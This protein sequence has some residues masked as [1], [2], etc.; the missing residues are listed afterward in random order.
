MKSNLFKYSVLSVGIV[1]AMGITGI[2]IAAETS[3]GST[4]TITNVATATY[5]VGNVLQTEVASNPVKVNITQSAAFNLTADNADGDKTDDYNKSIVVTP[6]GRVSF[7]HTLTNSGNID[8][9][10]TMSLAQGGTIPGITTQ[11]ASDYDLDL[12][13]VTYIIY[14]KVNKQL[15]STTVTGTEFQNKVISLPAGGKADITI[16]AKTRDNVGGELQNLT[17]EASSTFITTADS[18]KAKL[19]NINNSTTKVPVFK[20][21][22][23][24]GSTLDLNDSSDIVT[25]TVTVLNDGSAAYAS[26]A[27][28]ITVIDNLPAGLR[29]ASS[30]NL[31]V[32]NGASIVAGT[33]GAGQGGANDSILVTNLNLKVGETAT[34]KFDVQRDS[35][36]LT[37]I[38]KGV[39]NHAVVKLDLTTTD[40]GEVYDTTDPDDN[41]Q[42]TGI[43]YP[44]A[45]DSEIINGTAN[46]AAIGGDSTS[47]LIANQRAFD[48][49][50]ATSKEIPTTTSATTLVTHSAIITNT[51]K[52]I[53]GNEPGEIKFTIKPE[54]NNKVTVVTGSVELVYDPDNNPA[55]PN[56]TY[57]IQRD[58]NNDND[59][60]NALPKDGAPAWTGMAPGSTVTINYKTESK[61][62]VLG[63]TE[64]INITLVSGGTDAPTVVTPIV[65][66]RTE[67]KG[68]I[69]NKQQ[70]L[71]EGCQENATL[72]FG[73]GPLNAKPSDCIVYKISAFNNFS[74]ADERFFFT[75]TLIS[76]VI[77]QFGN[78][79]TVLT[80]S[81]TPKFDIKLDDVTGAAVKPATNKYAADLDATRVGGTV[82]KIAPQKYAAMMFAVR[83]NP[84]GSEVTP[85]TP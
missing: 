57:T 76:D 78:I 5:S 49:S 40:S 53:E 35:D 25:Y 38:V 58:G 51:G 59:L 60:T 46:G 33:N 4:P 39:V 82:T 43:Y 83:I 80:G 21:T 34:I 6:K 9:T 2:A 54:A 74:I 19:K 3:V 75:D 42:N 52:E 41:N 62:A 72:S 79:A 31:S 68:L 70:A 8:D 18:A 17:L 28:A 36:E 55:T 56:F 11:N 71:N 7:S 13:N 37:A 85:P 64:N 66:N 24:T 22:S 67:V 77:S 81:T 84:E 10:Y 26:D 23:R 14:D 65:T 1:S 15:S 16:S 50:G 69:L 12:T 20:I 63:T 47:P 29:L 32:S 45:D 44:A 73:L 61:G 27:T 48:I 30:P